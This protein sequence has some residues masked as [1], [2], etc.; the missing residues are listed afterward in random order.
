MEGIE[1]CYEVAVIGSGLIGSA[2][3]KYVSNQT[4]NCILIGP[5][6]PQDGVYAAWYDSGR[7]AEVLDQ[8][9]NWKH[10]ALKSIEKYGKIE[11]E[12]GIEFYQEVGFLTVHDDKASEVEKKEFVEK[13]QKEGI[14]CQSIKPD[15]RFLRWPESCQA[16]FQE[17]G[18]L[19]IYISLY[20]SG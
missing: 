18:K 6:E 16:Y 4:S 5:G 9:E 15:F 8:N 12:S 20:Q 1:S 3:A 10:L 2:A 7:I 19:Y 13:Y 11:T 14:H 17:K